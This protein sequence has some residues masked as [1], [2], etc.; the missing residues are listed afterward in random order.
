MQMFSSDTCSRF[1]L[2]E[3]LPREFR[4]R[5]GNTCLVCKRSLKVHHDGEVDVMPCGKPAPINHS[6][7]PR[8]V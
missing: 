1:E 4:L 8:V 7:P 6:V 3:S 5:G 2:D